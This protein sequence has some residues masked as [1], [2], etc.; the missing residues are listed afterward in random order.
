MLGLRPIGRSTAASRTPDKHAGIDHRKREGE[1][2]AFWQEHLS[3]SH[4][5]SFLLSSVFRP[6]PPVLSLHS[7]STINQ[8][9]SGVAEVDSVSLKQTRQWLSTSLSGYESVNGIT[10][11]DWGFLALLCFEKILVI[12]WHRLGVFGANNGRKCLPMSFSTNLKKL[13]WIHLHKWML[14]CFLC[15]C[16][17]LGLALCFFT[18]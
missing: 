8:A 14:F 7:N 3:F 12:C 10:W 13:V 4:F 11:Q 15:R 2:R 6:P 18:W 5:I 16:A 9:A 1:T 17:F